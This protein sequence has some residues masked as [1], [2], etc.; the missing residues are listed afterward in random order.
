[1]AIEDVPKQMR[2]APEWTH[3]SQPSYL[4]GIRRKSFKTN[5]EAIRHLSAVMKDPLQYSNDVQRIYYT[6]V[7]PAA[8]K[9]PL[10]ADIK[11]VTQVVGRYATVGGA[12]GLYL[13]F[14]LFVYFLN[15]Y[16]SLN[17]SCCRYC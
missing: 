17:Y 1:M 11:K 8:L 10:E 13:I 3:F 16:S 5:G 6:E 2:S 7:N 14:F 4:E 9:K 15:I 12:W